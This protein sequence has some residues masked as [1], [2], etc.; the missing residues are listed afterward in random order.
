MPLSIRER[1]DPVSESCYEV[2]HYHRILRSHLS[3]PSFG[4]S[5][6]I[7]TVLKLSTAQTTILIDLHALYS[8]L[9]LWGFSSISLHYLFITSDYDPLYGVFQVVSSVSP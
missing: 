3:S 9:L 8:A 1:S 4:G 2:Q 6:E 5:K 7:C